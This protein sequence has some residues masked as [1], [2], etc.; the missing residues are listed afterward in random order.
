MILT[1]SFQFCAPNTSA[2]SLD[3]KHL[4]IFLQIF[5]QYDTGAEIRTE[6]MVAQGYFSKAEQMFQMTKGK[7]SFRQQ[8]KQAVS[9]WGTGS[10]STAAEKSK[11]E[12]FP[13]H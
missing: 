5:I 2:A 3:S 1:L 12:P 4:L 10:L 9:A 6:A 7:R 13:I 11:S 8:K